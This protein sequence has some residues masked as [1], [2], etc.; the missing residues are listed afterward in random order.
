MH[1]IFIR[2]LMEHAPRVGKSVVKAYKQVIER[3]YFQIHLTID[4]DRKRK[5]RQ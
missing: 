2:L 1:N 5:E 3:K 4:F